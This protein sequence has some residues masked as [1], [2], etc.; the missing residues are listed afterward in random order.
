MRQADISV[1]H[2]WACGA[3]LHDP[4]CVRAFLRYTRKAEKEKLPR[5]L[6]PQRDDTRFK[7]MVSLGRSSALMLPSWKRV[8]VVGRRKYRRR[9]EEKI[10]EPRLMFVFRCLFFIF[11]V[12]PSIAHPSSSS[13]QT[14]VS[15]IA[16]CHSSSPPSAFLESCASRRKAEA[17]SDTPDAAATVMT[18]LG[19]SAAA[20]AARGRHSRRD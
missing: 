3:G 17:V 1:L 7:G 19:S 4:A 9:K 2:H 18:R 11:F 15:M 13:P 20:A 16:L 10:F 14:V 8:K 5:P 12:L 6:I